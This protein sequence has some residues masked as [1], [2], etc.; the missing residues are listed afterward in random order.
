MYRKYIKR[1]L[2]LL[3]A[4][5]L[6]LVLSPITIL[7]I[8]ALSVTRKH[9]LFFIQ[10]RPGKDGKL[11]KILKF[12]TMNNNTDE[13]GRL[14]P[15]KDRLTPLGR[16]LRRTS[17]DEIPQLLNVI[18]GEMSLVGPRPLLPEYLQFYSNHQARRHEVRPGITGWAQVNGR[19]EVSWP[20]K[21]DMDVWYVDNLSFWL[22]VKILFHTIFKVMKR[23]GISSSTSA[24]MERF[25]GNTVT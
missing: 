6:F 24:T 10:D 11:F 12:K 23:E 1:L 9:Q 5:F 21:F 13:Y 25:S 4:I 22:D 8:L 15:D 14:L 19:N 18:K 20:K 7:V 16:F 17:L 3:H 2:D